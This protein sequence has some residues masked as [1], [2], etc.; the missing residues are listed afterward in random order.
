MHEGRK[1]NERRR[2]MHEGRKNKERRRGMHEGKEA[3]NTKLRKR[4]EEI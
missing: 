4:V 3:R 1:N 2:G